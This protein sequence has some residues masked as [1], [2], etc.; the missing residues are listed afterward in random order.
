MKVTLQILIDQVSP[1]LV[2]M[3]RSIVS[4]VWDENNPEKKASA[5]RS[6]VIVAIAKHAIR[7]R[8]C[9]KGDAAQVGATVEKLWVRGDDLGHQIKPGVTDRTWPG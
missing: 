6:N 8:L 5:N 3:V 1:E 4:I 2:S 9:Q 7:T